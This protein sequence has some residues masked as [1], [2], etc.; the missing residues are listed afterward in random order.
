MRT[1]V[2]GCA[3]LCG[4]VGCR[5][6]PGP[7]TDAERA[8]IADTAAALVR[9]IFLEGI[10]RLDI[11]RTFRDYS[12]DPDAQ[13]VINGR[14]FASLEEY[15]QAE[16]AFWPE[17]DSLDARPTALRILVLG[18]D[19]ALVVAPVAFGARLAG[20]GVVRGEAVNTF[21]LQRRGGRWQVVHQ[22]ESVA[23]AERVRRELEAQRRR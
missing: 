20:G 3:L 11:A 8:A 7:L 18:P 13:V 15:R 12:F 4:V 14:S 1:V 10:N 9:G 17:L 2:W 19:A 6:R 5:A 23:D 21:V 16:A 22:H